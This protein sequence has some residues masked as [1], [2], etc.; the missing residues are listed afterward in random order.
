[1]TAVVETPYDQ[2]VTF[3]NPTQGDLSI[4]G[5]SGDHRIQIIDPLGA[6]Y[7]DRWIRGDWTLE[8]GGWPAGM[9]YLLLED[10]SGEHRYIQPI[11]KQ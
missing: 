3:P 6:V 9:Y 10:A 8:M 1:E 4:R 2:V 11:F 5:L 7:L